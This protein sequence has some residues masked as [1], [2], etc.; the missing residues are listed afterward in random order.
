DGCPGDHC[1]AKDDS[2]DESGQV[3]FAF[4]VETG[5]LGGFAPDE[6]ATIGAA[7]IREAGGDA[8]G[9][10]GIEAAC[11]EVV[12]EEER[13]SALDG[14][15]IDAVVHEIGADG[16]METELESDL[17]LGADA[18]GRT[19]ENG[20]FPAL[21]VE[22]EE[23]AEAANAAQDIAIKRLL[24]EKLDA[25]L[26]AIGGMKIDASSGVSDGLGSFLVG[27]GAGFLRMDSAAMR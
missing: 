19:N 22:A 8:F 12:E 27:H 17:E 18:I 9:D 3:V 6:G 25:L 15:V 2:D 20:V 11:G 24:G 7:G 21:E 10:V 5:H 26:G 1:V 23:S 16:V 14:D 4:G 13:R